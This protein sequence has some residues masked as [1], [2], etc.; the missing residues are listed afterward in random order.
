MPDA[1]LHQISISLIPTAAPVAYVGAER[2]MNEMPKP[3][4]VYIVEDS[5]I[6]ER[7]LASAIV[8]AGA[9]VS[10]CAGLGVDQCSGR[11]KA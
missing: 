10:G 6:V 1:L 5:E 2:V 7:L 9:E 8:A 11:G 4:Q 3:L